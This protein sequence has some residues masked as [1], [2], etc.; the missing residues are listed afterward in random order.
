MILLDVEKGSSPFYKGTKETTV[1]KV[2]GTDLSINV[3]QKKII[4]V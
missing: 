4:S 2:G 1:D 3:F